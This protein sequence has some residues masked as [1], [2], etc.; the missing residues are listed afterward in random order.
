MVA[1]ADDAQLEWLT[2]LLKKQCECKATLIGPGPDAQPQGRI[3]GRIV[4]YCDWGIQYEADPVHAEIVLRELGLENARPVG[5]PCA[6]G[7]SEPSAARASS[8]EPTPSLT[9]V[10]KAVG[11][12]KGRPLELPPEECLPEPDSP[13]LVGDALKRYQS[14]AAR[15]N[16]LALDRP[17]LQ[18][19]TKERMRRM[20]DPTEN[21]EAKLKRAGRYLKG[22]MRAVLRFPWGN[23]EMKATAYV[24]SDFAGCQ[25]TRKSTGAELSSGMAPA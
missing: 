5:S 17:D 13:P 4:T 14:V 11:S 22:A 21:D 24:D 12:Q 18:Y 10:R 16:Y 7:P 15:L 20:T 25:S 23:P 3:L 6:E 8:Q 9:D 19:A 1:A 2:R